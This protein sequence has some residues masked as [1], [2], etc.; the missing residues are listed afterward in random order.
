E[1]DPATRIPRYHTTAARMACPFNCSFCAG[2]W[3]RRELYAGKGP[4]RRYR[5]VGHIVDE[6]RQAHERHPNIEVVQFWDEV[7][8][9]RAPE[10]WLDEFCERYPREV[11]LPF[12]IWSHPGLLTE[13]MVVKLKAAGLHRVVLGVESGSQH[14]RREVLNRRETDE[15]V[16]RTGEMLNRHEV[17]VGYDFI[18]DLPWFTEENCRGTFETVMRLPHPFDVGMHSLA[19]LPCTD[20]TER[21]LAEGKIRPEEVASAHRPLPERFESFLWKS[22]LSAQDRHATYWHTLIYLASMPFVPRSLLRRLARLRP[23]LQLYPKPLVVA[24]EAARTKKET[25]RLK[26]H[27]AIESVYPTL[28]GFLA[29]HPTLGRTLNSCARGLGRLAARIMTR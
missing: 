7:F 11:G 18:V 13:E 23:L 14:V 27:A 22:T 12:E 3:F 15:T 5:S 24:A 2:P 19:F 20:I 28:G 10:G 21:A 26:L 16:L 9:V 4:H 25:G 1:C 8:A 29:R 6:I 17:S